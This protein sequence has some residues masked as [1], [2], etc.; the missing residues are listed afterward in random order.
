MKIL[1]TGVAGQL[2]HDCVEE[3]SHY[4]DVQVL[5]ID[6]D[7]LDLT[8][9]LDV[10]NFIQQNK[11]DAIIHCAA[12]TN[13]DAAETKKSEAYSVNVLGTKFLTEASKL[14]D[15]KLLYISTDYV[16]DGKGNQP[17]KISSPVDPINYYGSTKLMGEECVK[18]N[19][20]SFIVRTSWVYGLNGNNFVKT[21][22]KL[23]D[24]HPTI[25]VVNDQIGSPTYTR[26]LSKLICKMIQTD[27]YGIYHATNEGFCSWAEFASQIFKNIKKNVTVQNISTKE[28]ELIKPNQARRPLN[29]RLDKTSLDDQ[30]FKRLPKWKD[31]LERYLKE[32]GY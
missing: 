13:V 6:I 10:L 25:S 18:N 23:A 7:D 32:L 30:G 24:S 2:G 20:K 28:Y 14:I 29:S 3:L 5:G 17:Y 21:M 15:A 4:K 16:F 1:V 9:E 8:N 27:K 12:W 22:I 31:A 26:D 19:P 11:P